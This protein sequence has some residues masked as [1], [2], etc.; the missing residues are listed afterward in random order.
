MA[1]RF[2]RRR[3]RQFPAR[4][5]RHRDCQY[6]SGSTTPQTGVGTVY[7]GHIWKI[8]S[9]LTLDYGLRWIWKAGAMKFITVG[10]SWPERPTNPEVNNIL[11]AQVYEGTVPDAAI[12]LLPTPTHTRSSPRLGTRFPD[13]FEDHITGEAVASVMLRSRAS[14]TSP[15]AAIPG[16]VVQPVDV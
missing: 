4:P 1:C 9:R 10:P 16:V 13:Q 12:Q 5:D 15:D 2:G 11:G 14:A 6:R 7:S 3:L 8:T